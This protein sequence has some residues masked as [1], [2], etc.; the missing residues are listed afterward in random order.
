MRSGIARVSALAVVCLAIVALPGGARAC[1]CEV[2]GPT[3]AHGTSLYGVPWVIRANVY[4]SGSRGRLLTVS[5]DLKTSYLSG[6]STSF[7]LP[8]PYG[9]VLSAGIGT[10]VDPYPES[11]LRGIAGRGVVALTV[12]MDDGSE[13]MIEPQPA[14]TEVRRRFPWLG[15]LRFFHAFYPAG[16]RPVLVTALDREGAVIARGRLVRGHFSLSRRSIRPSRSG[17]R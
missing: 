8:V 5:F 12:E 11:D 3:V 4:G 13:L 7:E 17:S 16:P 10:E 6:S 9:F 15:G 1:A 14:P 2:R